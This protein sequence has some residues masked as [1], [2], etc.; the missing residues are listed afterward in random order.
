MKVLLILSVICQAVLLADE[1]V[2]RSYALEP[3]DVSWFR[4]WNEEAWTG[5]ELAKAPFESPLFQ[6]GDKLRD[7][8]RE[9]PKIWGL[10]KF[11][12][13]LIWNERVERFVMRAEESVHDKFQE[14]MEEQLVQKMPQITVSVYS[15]ENRPEW[16]GETI[17]EMLPEGGELVGEISWLAFEGEGNRVSTPGKKLVVEAELG[18]SEGRLEGT[19]QVK[20]RIKE[21]EFSFKS[22]VDS[23]VGLPW[24][25][26]I[27]SGDGKR[28][29]FMVVGCEWVRSNGAAYDDW[30]LTEDGRSP[31]RDMRLDHAEGYEVKFLRTEKEV[32][33]YRVPRGTLDWLRRPVVLVHE[34]GEPQE[35]P[36]AADGEVA[37]IRPSPKYEGD[38]PVFKG[39]ERSDLVDLSERMRENGVK[40]DEGQFVVLRSSTSQLYV[41]LDPADVE[42]LLG[43]LK[44]ACAGPP[45][46]IL[47]AFE[48]VESEGQLTQEQIRNGEGKRIRRI[49]GKGMAGAS[50]EVTLG[51]DLLVEAEAMVDG[52]E[53]LL[54]VSGLLSEVKKKREKASFRSALMVK[55]GVPGMVHEGR[56]GEKWRTWVLTGTV[57]K[58]VNESEGKK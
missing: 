29:L 37:E 55:D 48:L 19:F 26:E 15:F 13:E 57:V 6:E 23:A 12:G 2:V 41:R 3:E 58:L 43:C 33:V 54:Q 52:D 40:I 5:R 39:M 49:V 14:V 24:V 32:R 34:N 20:S 10:E 38:H 30:V 17:W 46:P 36:F 18:F 11:E 21:A 22:F 28:S 8:S 16:R 56:F 4:E 51:K 44:V 7:W 25:S 47:L 9:V 31:L 27:G 1:M 35:D 50:M 45:Q 53:D 42:L